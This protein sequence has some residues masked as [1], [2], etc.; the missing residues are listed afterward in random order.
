VN[1]LR[2]AWRVSR[3]ELL[4]VL[5]AGFV[6]A[7]ASVL[8]ALVLNGAN[9]GC[10]NVGTSDGCFDRRYFDLAYYGEWFQVAYWLFPGV[11]G[12]LLGVIVAGREIE[13]GTAQFSWSL[14]LSRPRW[15]LERS[16]ATA[17]PLLGILVVLAATSQIVWSAAHPGL[18]P[19][20]S[21]SGFGARG[22]SV[23]V[24]GIVVYCVAVLVGAIVGRVLPAFLV[25]AAVVVPLT[26]FGVGLA[27]LGMVPVALDVSSSGGIS[28][29][30][31]VLDE[32]YRA[33]DG[34][35]VT[36]EEATAL[37]PPNVDVGE[38]VYDQR[39]AV[40]IPGNRYPEVLLR[41][42][43]WLAAISAASSTVALAVVRRRRLR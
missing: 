17:F 36:W 31:L 19:D 37:A 28:G 6:L 21:L 12:A 9:P 43:A 18:S 4:I 27:T 30:P 15:L 40:G 1:V 26:L 23:I 34:A 5:G 32:L 38:W 39:V 35:L 3:L 10:I 20:A 22:A 8:F 33:P 16:V 24:R 14:A 41:E 29:G 2:I 42:T 25:A 7:T 13:T 11:A